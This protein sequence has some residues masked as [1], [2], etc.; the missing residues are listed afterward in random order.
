MTEESPVSIE[1]AG[2][3]RGK[4]ADGE[5][6]GTIGFIGSKRGRVN[7]KMRLYVG[8]YF[9]CRGNRSKETAG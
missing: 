7:M 5:E 6:K 4:G 3:K 8:N 2:R 1:G 9:E